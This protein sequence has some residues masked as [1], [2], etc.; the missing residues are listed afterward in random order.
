MMKRSSLTILCFFLLSGCI[1]DPVFDMSNWE[2]YQTS[3]TAIKAK[4][5][6]DDL[7]RL[8]MAMKYLAVE[9]ML[10]AE[11]DV[12]MAS[13]VAAL[14]NRLNPFM[15]FNQLRFK[16]NGKSA[17]AVIKDLSMKLDAEISRAETRGQIGENVTAAVEV[18]SPS[19]YWKRNGRLEQPAIEFAVFNG[20]KSPISRIYF[21][22][23]LM[24][25]NRSVP[26]ARQDYVE[27]FKGGLEPREKRQLTLQP[28]GDWSDPQL[29][30]LPNS[31]LK[32]D[33]LNFEDASG[34]RM[35]GFDRDSLELKRKVRAALD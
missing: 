10:K 18:T 19:Y 23:A 1:F 21:R 25:P 17:V 13:N 15:M 4:L 7:R 32:V 34:Q 29:K 3:L 12:Q 16:I 2:T 33:V 9:N 26:W 22:F 20:S 30:N 24:T 35:I 27:V 5:S 6:N 28:R 14:G 8:D 31:E 11:A